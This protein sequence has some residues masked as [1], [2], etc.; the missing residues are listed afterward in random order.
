VALGGGLLAVGAPEE[1]STGKVYLWNRVGPIWT[2]AGTLQGTGQSSFAYFGIVAVSGDTVA[3]GARS[4]VTGGVD[5]G[6]VYVFVRSGGSW[7]EQ[8]K[9]LASDGTSSDFFGVDVAL[10]GDTLLVGASHADGLASESGAVYVFTR[11]GTIWTE[12]AKLIAPDGGASDLFGT[13]VALAGDTAVIGSPSSDITTF[14]DGAAYVFQ[15]SGSSWTFQQ[16]LVATDASEFD[17]FGVS[18]DVQ[19]DRAVVGA[20]TAGPS[21]AEQSGA[22]YVFERNGTAWSQ[23]GRL[24]PS[25][26]GQF[27]NFGCSVDLQDD[28]VAIGARDENAVYLYQLIA[29]SWVRI[30]RAES[31]LSDYDFG[32]DVAFDGTELAVGAPEENSGGQT[33]GGSV[34]TY[35]V[36]NSFSAF[37]FGDGSGTNCPCNNTSNPGYERGC[38]HSGSNASRLLVGGVA[39]VSA[40][41]VVLLGYNMRP[42]TAVYIQGSNFV[43]L[44]LGDVYHDGLRCAGAPIVRLGSTLNAGNGSSTYPNAGNPTPISVRGAVSP[45]QVKTYQIVFR[46]NPPGFCTSGTLN[47]TNGVSVVWGP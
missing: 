14:N 47:T 24:Q 31:P 9:L 17:N 23:T 16:K 32:Y 1:A 2:P 10:A 5:A 46:D 13:S 36:N 26:H 37:C 6:A 44:G 41:S 11:S 4:Q 19:G 42:T 39:S 30:Q 7:S 12:Q 25:F 8:Q 15:G 29:G 35:R 43:N 3:V 45:G 33:W 28:V 34:R 20:D 40:D 21:G 27:D 22:A 18:I 38:Q